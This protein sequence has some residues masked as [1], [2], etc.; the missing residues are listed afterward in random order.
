VDHVFQ[1]I[2]NFADGRKT[3]GYGEKQDGYESK[4]GG[5]FF[6]YTE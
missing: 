2:Q 3:N 5:S 1:G 6:G 4:Y